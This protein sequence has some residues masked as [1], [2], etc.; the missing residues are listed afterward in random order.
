ME[1]NFFN[2]IKWDKNSPWEGILTLANGKT[3]RVDFD[4]E[5]TEEEAA[6]NT[7]NFVVTN[8]AQISRKVAVL[9]LE[10]YEDWV[11]DDIVTAEQ[12][13]LKI[14]LSY[15]M[16]WE[17]GKGYLYYETNGND[18]MFTDH[19]LCVWLDADGEIEEIGFDG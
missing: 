8:E 11:N 13:V 14:D 18:E 19:V 16:F 7:L 15:I 10:Q 5:E 6:R 4:V 12:L 9:L 1:D 3:V 2:N 17:G